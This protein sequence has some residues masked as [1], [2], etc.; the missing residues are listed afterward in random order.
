MSKVAQV[1]AELQKLSQADLR[2]VR[3]WLDD[4]IEDKLEF[5]PEFEAGI[6][7]SECEMSQGQHP[8][9]RQP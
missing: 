3:N 4:V 8:R 6:Q 7:Q 2:Q 1:E 5:T 9:T